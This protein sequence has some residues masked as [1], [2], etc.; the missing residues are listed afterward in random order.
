MPIAT[1]APPEAPNFPEELRLRGVHHVGVVVSDLGRSLD[2]YVAVTGGEVILD[3][4][5]RGPRAAR[6]MGLDVESM[7]LRFAL[8][9]LD[10]TILELIEFADPAVRRRERSSTDL[11]FTHIAFEV[12][13]IE[14]ITARLR[15]AGIDVIAEPYTFQ[16]DD[17]APD[18]R[19]ATFAYF[20]DPDGYQL[21]VFQAA[22]PAQRAS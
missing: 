6:H 4:P 5:M 15:G 17:G 2:F 3:N 18:V 1:Q 12:R 7:R 8:I 11:G 9:Q 16:E 20:R 14:A 19:G 13:D 10:N 21:E 22:E